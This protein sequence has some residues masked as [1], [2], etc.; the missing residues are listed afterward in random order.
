MAAT[1]AYGL[2]DTITRRERAKKYLMQYGTIQ[3][4]LV[5]LEQ[6]YDNLD[7]QRFRWNQRYDT[8]GGSSSE[9]RDLGDIVANFDLLMEDVKRRMDGLRELQDEIE[10]SVAHVQ[11]IH[12]KA[13]A[14]L[15]E[16]YFV[17]GQSPD[18]KEIAPELRYSEAAVKTHH[19]SGLDLV[20]DILEEGNYDAKLYSFLSAKP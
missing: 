11:V 2:E 16:K 6:K 18:W 7:S 15:R 1:T 5:K 12:P 3:C 8:C 13:A 10:A 20:A 4:W 19:V 14:A 9:K 17:I